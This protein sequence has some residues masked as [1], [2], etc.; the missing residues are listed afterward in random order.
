MSSDS[1]PSASL[2][3][4]EPADDTQRSSHGTASHVSDYI[5]SFI[6]DHGDPFWVGPLPAPE[7][8]RPAV[9]QAIEAP[10]QVDA[11]NSTNPPVE[12]TENPAGT[13]VGGDASSQQALKPHSPTNKW[14]IAI[15]GGAGMNTPDIAACESIGNSLSG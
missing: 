6:A 13:P 10:V 1:S 14:I 15:H 2:S 3:G 4:G 11:G 5:S 8:P 12:G 9:K 7:I